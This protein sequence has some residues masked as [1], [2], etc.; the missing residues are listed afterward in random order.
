MR[1]S[2]LLFSFTL[3]ACGDPAVTDS[4][5][6]VGPSI[7]TAAVSFALV[8]ESGVIS[9][10][11]LGQREWIPVDLSPSQDGKL[12]VVQR[13][14]RHPD[15]TDETECTSASAIGGANDCASLGGGTVEITDPAAAEPATS[16]NDRAN[17]VVDYNAWHFLRRPSAIAFGAS[18]LSIEPGDPGSI[19]PNTGLTVLTETLVLKNTFATCHEHFTGNY[20]DQPP[21]IGPT[22]WTSDP[23]IYNGRNGNEVWSNGSHLDMV[24]STPYCMGIAYDDRDLYWTFNGDIGTIDRYDFQVPHVPGH[25]NHDDGEVTRYFFDDPLARVP[26]VPSNLEVAGDY[27]YIADTGNGRVVRLNR[28]AEGTVIDTFRTHENLVG[29]MVEDVPLEEVIGKSALA[30]EWGE[31]VEPSGLAVLNEN[32]LVVANH[33]SGHLT[34]IRPSGEIVRTI[35]TGMGEGLGGVTVLDGVIYFAHM[36]ERRVY[37]VDVAA[38]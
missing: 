4:D 16:S 37:R 28:M 17:L 36:R 20:T 18:E 2:S 32:T 26:D 24:H 14:P 21:F 19:D 29:D 34:F 22:L 5:A 31:R 10:P 23:A 13:L 35:D 9:A 7:E 11:G 38:E 33:A 6:S 30:A 12:W 1:R 3:V 25:H 27:L 8:Y 15:F